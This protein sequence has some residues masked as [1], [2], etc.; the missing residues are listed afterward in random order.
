MIKRQENDEFLIAWSNLETVTDMI[1]FVI[2]LFQQW[3]AGDDV[4]EI[5]LYNLSSEGCKR[6]LKKACCLDVLHNQSMH[7]V[8]FICI[9]Q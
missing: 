1:T 9:F 3:L 4:L 2:W 7:E 6:F 5:F 8:Y